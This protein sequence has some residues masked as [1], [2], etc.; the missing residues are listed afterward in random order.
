M[1]ETLEGFRCLFKGREDAWG[2]VQGKCNKTP[3]TNDHYERHLKGEESLGI[4]PLLDDGTCYFFA[5]DL[6]EKDFD[7]AKKIRQELINSFIPV[8]I[9]E[10]KSKGYHIYGFAFE[11]FNAKEVRHILAHVLNKLNIKA[12][13]FPKQDIVSEAVPYGNYINLPCFGYTRPFL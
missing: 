4:Y 6:D 10:S 8:Y 2:S 3:I 5:V 1:D 13:I 12:E 7:K 11:K 9:A